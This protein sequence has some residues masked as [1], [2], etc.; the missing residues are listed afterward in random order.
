MS[1][2]YA[3]INTVPNS[4]KFSLPFSD[5]SG[6]RLEVSLSG[7]KTDVNI[8]D[9]SD[10]ILIPIEDIEWLREVLNDINQIIKMD[11][12]PVEK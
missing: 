7:K 11:V 5:N 6:E 4:I 9:G 2:N 12:K 1:K 10:S 3:Y 8:K